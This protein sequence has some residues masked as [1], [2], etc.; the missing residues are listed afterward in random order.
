MMV[1]RAKDGDEWMKM[2][3]ALVDTSTIAL[4]AAEAKDVE[5]L[6][7]IGG[8]IDEAC[9]NCHKKDWPDY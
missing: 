6:Y 4:R 8:P 9:E 1:P 5:G 2:A 3:Q 7:Q